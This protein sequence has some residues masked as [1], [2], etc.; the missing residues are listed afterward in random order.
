MVA[1]ATVTAT[2]VSTGVKHVIVERFGAYAISPLD[3][4]VYVV[5]VTATGFEK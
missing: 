3:A 4:G 1:N 2:E 5:T